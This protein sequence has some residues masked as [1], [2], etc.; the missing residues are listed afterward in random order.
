MKMCYIQVKTMFLFCLK[1]N[2]FTLKQYGGSDHNDS[3]QQLLKAA[4]DVHLR[5]DSAAKTLFYP[6]Q[7]NVETVAYYCV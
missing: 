1:K 2:E 3:P 5:R 6:S 7:I 4:S